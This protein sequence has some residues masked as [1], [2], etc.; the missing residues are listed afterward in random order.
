MDKTFTALL[1][2][3]FSLNIQAQQ[4]SG[5]GGPITNNGVPTYFPIVV[6]G[7]PTQINSTFGLETVCIRI[8][9]SKVEQLY[10]HLVSPSGIK[11]ELSNG[12]SCSGAN[13]IN[14]CFNSSLTNS[15]TLGTAPYNSN[16]KPIGYFGRFNNGQNPNGTWKLSVKDWLA[17]VDSGSV[18]DWSITFGNAPSPPINFSSSNLPIVIINTNNQE[19]TDA[20][21]TANM[22]IIDNGAARNYLTDAW[23]GYNGKINIHERGHSSKSHEKSSFSIETRDALGNNLE[24]SLLGMPPDN[25]WV[26]GAEYADKTLLRNRLTYYL[27]SQMGNYAA[28]TR[29]VEVVINGEYYGVYTFEE[30]PKRSDFRIPVAKLTAEENTSPSVTGGY[31]FKIDRTDEAGWFSYSP[32]TAT[33]NHFYYQYV[34]PK[35]TAITVPQQNYIQ[36]V[37]N[38]FEITMNSADFANL[39]T[40]YPKFIDPNS[41][42]D[43]LIVTEMAKNVDGYRLSTYLSKERISKGGKIKI[44][45]VWDFDLAWHN[46]NYGA[47]FNS[48]GWQYEQSDNAYPYP[49]WWIRFRQ[50]PAFNNRLQCRWHA[51]RQNVLKTENILAWIDA[52]V[53]ELNESQQRNFVQWPVLGAYIRP[54]PQDQAGATWQTEISDLKNWITA[55]IGWMDSQIPY[56][57][58]CDTALPPP[59]EQQPVEPTVLLPPHPNPFIDS[60]NITYLVEDNAHVK[61]EMVNLLGDHVAV[62]YSADKTSGLYTEK[63]TT[64]PL[65]AGMYVMK[66]SVNDQVYKQKIVKWGN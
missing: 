39:T 46:A 44:G 26:L 6:S 3:L 37:M 55:R 59:E 48:W 11:V 1:L 40:G 51:F 4:F 17:L 29:S 15:V 19:I 30:K 32:G 23:N 41:F 49:S 20:D 25:D 27:A 62:L 65:A 33:V 56:P 18:I 66:L 42:V 2:F 38:D 47:A 13:Y 61:V 7:L 10:I 54:N 9:H 5:T 34:Y 22:G 60:F 35:D 52:A 14:T 63:I 21:L 36:S 50:D 16:Y 53:N 8:N 24:V 28:R 45:P 31:I 43:F 57:A 12:N 64:P 58:A